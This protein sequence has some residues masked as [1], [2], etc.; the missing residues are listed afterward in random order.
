[1]EVVV[2]E[3]MSSVLNVIGAC[4]YGVGQYGIFLF[5]FCVLIWVVSLADILDFSRIWW[6]GVVKS[7]EQ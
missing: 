7:M 4:T 2:L 3:N 5:L 1:M 6:F